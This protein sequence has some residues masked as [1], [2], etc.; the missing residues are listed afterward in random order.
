MSLE[1]KINEDMQAKNGHLT[2]LYHVDEVVEEL[3]VVDGQFVVLE[4]DPVLEDLLVKADA[5]HKIAGVPNG[6]SHQEKPVVYGLEF[7]DGLQS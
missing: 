4:D 3:L 5:Q 2:H 6:L 1:T 7:A